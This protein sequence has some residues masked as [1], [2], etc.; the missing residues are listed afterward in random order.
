MR[1][2][3]LASASPRRSAL[4]GQIGWPFRVVPAPGAEPQPHPG[5]TA[6]AFVQRAALAKAAAV[7]G[8]PETICLGADTVVV[9]SQQI[10]GKPRDEAHARQML[11]SLS[12]R[13]HEVWS[14]L[15]LLVP[16][17]VEAL[18]GWERRAPGWVHAVVTGVCFRALSEREIDAYVATGEPLDK[19]GS[20]AIQGLGA[21]LVERIDG[22]Y[23]NVVGL[24]LVP[25]ILALRRWLPWPAPKS[26]S[27]R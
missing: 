22:S 12:G 16:E 3:I 25:L 24:P 27:P 5:E 4:L 26:E 20:Y 17:P 11:H 19:A 6:S 10:L 13:R 1:E 23:P 9:Q 8:A 15:A 14:G 7:G 18:P 2:L 21:G